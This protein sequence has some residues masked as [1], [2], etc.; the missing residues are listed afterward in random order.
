MIKNDRQYRITKAQ[1]EKFESA[2]QALARSV[3]DSHVHPMIFSAQRNALYSQMEDLREQIREYEDLKSGRRTVLEQQSLDQLPLALIKARIAAGL[4]Q[5]DMAEKVGLKEQQIQR[6]EATEYASASFERLKAIARALNIQVYEEILLSSLKPSLRTLFSRLEEIGLD[7]DLILK[8]LIP[9]ETRALIEEHPNADIEKM[10]AVQAAASVSR[11]FNWG[12]SDI[13]RVDKSLV[14]NT[15]PVGLAR[16]KTS[17]RA[18]QRKLAAYTVYAHTLALLALDATENIEHRPIP[19]DAPIARKNIL[20]K[21]GSVTLESVLTYTWDLGI[22]VLPLHD[23]GAFHGA[24]WREDGRN[25]IVLKQQNVS[26]ARWLYDLLHELYHAGSDP[27]NED[28]A[29][30][31]E[32]PIDPERQDSDVE[33]AANY[34]AEDVMLDG[35][36]DELEEMCI[37]EAKSS[38]ERLKNVVPI[39]AKREG[40]ETDAL[41]NHMAHRLSAQNI[42]WWGAANN[43][44]HSGPSPWEIATRILLAKIDLTCLN[45]F[46]RNLLLRAVRAD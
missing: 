15:A 30:I 45:E 10:L 34:F 36:S 20:A 14:L 22:P 44:Q 3:P 38:V 29:I 21:Y 17:T 39:I 24:C 18:E 6:Y 5:R 43:L 35:R 26:Y 46:D 32:S 28:M 23:P 11:V 8:R 41:A 33:A 16:F 12:I 4:S 25:V 19:T 31:E 2:F 7:H 42:N 9:I 27:Q 1:A 13:F 37:K 40:V